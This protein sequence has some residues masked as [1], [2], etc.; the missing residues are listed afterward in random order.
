MGLLF[1]SRMIHESGG[2]WW[3]DIDRGKQKNLGKNLSR[4]HFGYFKSHMD[5]TRHEPWPLLWEARD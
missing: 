1:I 4:C 3:N 2:P 5:L